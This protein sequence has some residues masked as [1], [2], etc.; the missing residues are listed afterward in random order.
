VKWDELGGLAAVVIL[1]TIYQWP[2]I[3]RK[4]RKERAAFTLLT[5]IGSALAVLLV[6]F[7]D[8]P[9]P[10]QLVEKIYRPLGKMLE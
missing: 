1:M 10:T 6:Y 8:L 2:R 7:P 9:G 4:Q 3:G 5:A